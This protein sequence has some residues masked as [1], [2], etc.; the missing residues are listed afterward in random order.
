MAR[1]LII[2][3]D[4]LVCCLLSDAIGELGHNVRVRSTLQQGVEENASADFDVLFLDVM[5]PDGC[6]L[7]AIKGLK[8]A[9]SSPEVIIITGAGDPDSAELAIRSGAWDYIQK[10]LTLK[11]IHLPLLRVLEYRKAKSVQKK[12]VPLRLDSIV[13]KSRKIAACIEQLAHAV[14]SD[15][16]VL[17]TGETGTGKELFAR[18]LYENG[19]RCNHP[20]VVVDCAALPESI[21]ESLLF[22]HE[23]GAFTGAEKCHEGLIKQAHGG[24][25]FLDEVGE[26]PSTLQ[27]TFL[28]VLQ[29][30]RFRPVGG[31]HEETSDFRLIA[32]TNQDL[33]R[34]VASGSFRSDLLFRL[35]SYVIE[36][37]PLRE[38]REDIR[39]LV[40]R[41]LT[42]ACERSGM[43]M[44]GFSPDFFEVLEAY[45]WPGN[46]R[47]LHSTLQSA[48][49][50]AFEEPILYS[51]HLPVAIRGK[52][53]R[54]AF[55]R[56][57]IE[58]AHE[59][60]VNRAAPGMENPLP[61]FREYRNRLLEDGE[62]SY[63]AE[64][65]MKSR[66]EVA[67]AIRISGLSRTRLYDFLQKYNLSLS[68]GTPTE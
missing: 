21:V 45:D 1:I 7:D 10:P 34:M 15:A 4:P 50:S 11:T 26:L 2:D 61:L 53:A 18:A 38:R 56:N 59:N 36:L 5:L 67:E 46:V 39:E 43:R 13:G 23:K 9:K 54:L 19:P 16:N 64:L 66:G 37:P 20:F 33:E 40:L 32:A 14:A 3:D 44:K 47:E 49:T 57:S 48:L 31:K 24:T 6:G 27:K 12:A 29:E 25:L 35:R 65:V 55:N 41:F 62:G 17:I 58:A 30:R 42:K 60:S 22:G 8:N 68:M 51:Y 28:R 63:F 52:A